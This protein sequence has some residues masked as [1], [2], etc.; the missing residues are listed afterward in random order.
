MSLDSD[1]SDIEMQGLTEVVHGL[2]ELIAPDVPADPAF[3]AR[4]DRRL[5]REW[6]ALHRRRVL[7]WH[8]RPVFRLAALA[9]ALVVAVVG[10]AL[11]AG[12]ESA[13]M[14]GTAT[15]PLSPDALLLAGIVGLVVAAAALFWYMRRRR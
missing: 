2:Y 3:R 4:L 15:G 6:N 5:D 14:T 10:L 13:G 1:V 12:G 9:A 8:Q 11:V 7:R